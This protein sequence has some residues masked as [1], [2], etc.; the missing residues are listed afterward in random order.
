MNTRHNVYIQQFIFP[1]FWNQ[2]TLM[3]EKYLDCADWGVD[4]K[5]GEEK[6]YRKIQGEYS[7]S[8]MS[9]NTTSTSQN[10]LTESSILDLDSG[11]WTYQN[12]V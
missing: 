1:I 11:S 6:E 2:F 3:E 10:L 7:T 12:I 9:D 8:F 4:L 5:M